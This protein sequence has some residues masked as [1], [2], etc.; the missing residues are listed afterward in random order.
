MIILPGPQLLQVPRQSLV[1]AVMFQ[2]FSEPRVQ[3]SAAT[4]CTQTMVIQGFEIPPEHRSASA[5]TNK[6]EQ[7][8]PPQRQSLGLRHV[9]ILL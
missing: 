6:A 4:L 9:D 8:C 2:Q 7:T 3:W 1:C 5:G